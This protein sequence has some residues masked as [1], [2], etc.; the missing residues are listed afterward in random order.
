[1]TR[2]NL[3]EKSNNALLD[4]LGLPSGELALHAV[5][6]NG[7]SYAAFIRLAKLLCIDVTK[8]A[9][10]LSITPEA[11]EHRKEVGR[12]TAEESDKIYRVICVFSATVAF[13]EDDHESAAIWFQ[14]KVKGLGGNRPLD[15]LST[16]A[17]GNAVI[18]LIQRLEH[19]VFV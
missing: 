13:F 7:I 19:G 15:L 5:I 14:S 18:E 4:D 17:G 1:M 6:T 2:Y 16:S 9:T 3:N 11:L 8:L 10:S 12:F